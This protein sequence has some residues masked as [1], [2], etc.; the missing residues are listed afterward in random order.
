MP[1]KFGGAPKCAVCDKSVYEMEKI[2]AINKIFHKSCFTCGAF[3]QSGGCKRTLTLD[4]YTDHAGEP[5]CK[6]CYSKLFGIKGYGYGSGAH[7]LSSYADVPKQ[8]PL[9]NVNKSV[10]VETILV[11]PPLNADASTEVAPLVTKEPSREP[12]VDES[13]QSP[14]GYASVDLDGQSKVDG[15]PIESSEQAELLSNEKSGIG[16]AVLQHTEEPIVKIAQND[17]KSSVLH[18]ESIASIVNIEESITDVRCNNYTFLM[19]EVP[20]YRSIRHQ[21]QFWVRIR[22]IKIHNYRLLMMQHQ[23]RS[24]FYMKKVFIVLDRQIQNM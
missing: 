23:S 13:I 12:T 11:S 3:V 8:N 15:L 5:F 24:Q 2:N 1:P 4:K 16:G 9:S 20:F 19:Y 17:L 7:V 10:E 14:I 22:M 18:F 6:G 21:K